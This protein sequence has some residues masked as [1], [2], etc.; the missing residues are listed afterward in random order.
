M[1]YAEV[2]GICPEKQ[3]AL[4]WVL[5]MSVLRT[6]GKFASPACHHIIR[7]HNHATLVLRFIVTNSY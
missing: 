6:R 1:S 3:W 5:S 7:Y 2:K 4:F